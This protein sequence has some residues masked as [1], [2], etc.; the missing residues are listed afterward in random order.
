[1]TL[2]RFLVLLLLL[3]V[4]ASV[5]PRAAAQAACAAEKFS[6]NRAFTTCTDLPRLG[7]SVHWTYDA[8][9]SS[10]SVAFVAAP[11]SSGGWVAWALNPTGDGM[12][13]AQALV[14]A[15]TTGGAY[16]VQTYP[17]TGLSLGSAGPI[18]YPTSG[19][20]AELGA[21]GKVRMF[22]T[23]KLQNGTGEVNQVWQVGPVSSGSIMPHAMGTANLAAKGKLN[24]VTGATTAGSTGGSLLH[25]KNVSY[26]YVPFLQQSVR[27]GIRWYA[28][29]SYCNK[30]RALSNG[31]KGQLV[32]IEKSH[33]FS[34]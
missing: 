20:A 2:A 33:F 4:A 11:P 9:T 6:A 18:A 8:A 13:G 25:K 29:V 5:P 12:I 21:D 19:L 3:V 1:M 23:L 34:Y 22:G 15:P 31:S 30:V 16:G 26:K 17:I 7:A 10:L 32:D 14:A 24:L 27:F 28:L